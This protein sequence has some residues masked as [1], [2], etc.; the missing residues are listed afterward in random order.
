MRLGYNTN[1]LQ[2]HRLDDALRLLADAGYEVVA[3]TPD[4]GHLDPYA[5][6]AA[7]VAR[8]ATLLET[9]GLAVVM[10]TGARFVLDPAH[11]HEP[12]LMTADPA[13]VARR[14]DYYD[15]VA[16]MGADLGAEVVS[17][18]AG[19]DHAPDESS[20]ARCR[21]GV[22]QTCDAIR[23]AGLTPALEPEPGMAIATIADFE[24]LAAALGDAAPRL[25]LDIG[26]LYAEW[27]GQPAE[28]IRRCAGRIAQV[29]LEDMRR[30]V[31]VHLE[32]GEGDV[33][34]AA[35]LAAL[36]ET[37][38]DGAVCFELSRSSHRAPAALAAC[39]DLWNAH[40][41]V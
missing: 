30:G 34:F 11:K 3:L 1:G 21:Q 4:V 27:E 16:R 10:E 31:H 28:L 9:L 35:D 5:A 23:A 22:E 19:V 2:N 41:R 39:R 18:W 38:Y 7:D 36:A 26:H 24:R 14:V 15:R 32:P 33:D 37:G 12:T 40:V 20:E 8:T 17:F 29:H 13:G 6:T 25:S